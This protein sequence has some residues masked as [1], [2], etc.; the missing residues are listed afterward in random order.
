V[1]AADDAILERSIQLTSQLRLKPFDLSILAS[2]VRK[3]GVSG[4]G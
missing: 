3:A 4:R 1:F 2:S